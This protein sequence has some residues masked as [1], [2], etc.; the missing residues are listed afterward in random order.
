ML[1]QGDSV[2]VTV[3]DSS[4][5]TGC[6]D[7]AGDCDEPRTGCVACC[8]LP[9]LL[10]YVWRSSA[11]LVLG[12]AVPTSSEKVLVWC[13]RC[14]GVALALCWCG[15]GEV[16]VLRWCC[17]GAACLEATVRLEEDDICL[18]T[19][20]CEFLDSSVTGV[21][22]GEDRAELRRVFGEDVRLVSAVGVTPLV[23]P[24]HSAVALLGAER[25]KLY[26]L[27]SGTWS[28]P[29]CCCF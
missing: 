13:W 6:G 7:C 29:S 24:E 18:S 2:P 4:S 19:P 11:T 27:K 9:D 28:Q 5:R 16:L 21:K 3:C 26:S 8:G 12:F 20:A 10:S 17:A 23:A 22:R 25:T 14:A 1:L 15:D